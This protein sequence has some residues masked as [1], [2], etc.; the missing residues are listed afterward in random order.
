M[1][2][3]DGQGNF[4]NPVIWSDV[5]DPDVIRVGDAFCMTSTTMHMPP[6]VPVMKS[7]NLV[8]WEIVN[9]VYDIMDACQ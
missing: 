9:Y 3:A 5:P 1:S 4:T 7:K 2:T 6:G 8:N